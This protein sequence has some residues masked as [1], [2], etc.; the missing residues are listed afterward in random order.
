MVGSRV[1]R[2]GNHEGKIKDCGRCF[3]LFRFHF[4][5]VS[6]STPNWSLS[7]PGKILP[8]ICMVSG[9]RVFF[10]SVFF[11]RLYDESFVG[12]GLFG[13]AFYRVSS[14][15]FRF[16]TDSDP[17]FIHSSKPIDGRGSGIGIVVFFH[18]RLGRFSPPPSGLR[19]RGRPR[20]FGVEFF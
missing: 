5:L 18:L 11:G 20:G 3:G 14:G 7:D 17:P 2:E 15:I 19:F 6:L 9:Q 12:L 13:L 16:E 8:I 10:F 1:F 4:S